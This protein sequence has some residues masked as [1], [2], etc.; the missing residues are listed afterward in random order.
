[1]RQRWRPRSHDRQKRYRCCQEQ[2]LHAYLAP[3]RTAWRRA[4]AFFSGGQR[5]DAEVS[6]RNQVSAKC[7][8]V[9]RSQRERGRS[10]WRDLRHSLRSFQKR[11]SDQTHSALATRKSQTG[12]KS[13]GCTSTPVI[14]KGNLAEI[15]YGAVFSTLEYEKKTGLGMAFLP[16]LG[17]VPDRGNSTGEEP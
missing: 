10:T 2:P 14:A 9:L 8:V 12:D 4:H 3:C 16:Q 7:S 17:I 1:M 5:R 6:A 11:N 13:H 15:T